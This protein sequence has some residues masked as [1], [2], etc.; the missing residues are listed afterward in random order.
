MQNRFLRQSALL[1]SLVMLLSLCF[2][3]ADA[4]S[5]R[6]KRTRRAKKP[7][8]VKPVITNPEIAPP[9]SEQSADSTE[10]VISTADQSEA[11]S[12]NE[13]PQPKKT[14]KTKSS[15][16]PEMQQTINQLSNQ[17]D[18]LSDKLTQMQQNDRTL[19]DMERLTRAEQR[20]ENL[21]T[22]QVEVEGKLAD[23]QG[24]AG[25]DRVS[26]ATGKY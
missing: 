21:R 26:I 6:K 3:D 12:T 16:D 7:A 19:I 17:V 11:E 18:R 23:L 14:S 25:T 4:Q 24:K 5:R 22:Q 15:S 9:G 8:A 10:K 1:V 20:A 2:I 13:T